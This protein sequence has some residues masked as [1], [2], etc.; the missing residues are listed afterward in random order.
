MGPSDRLKGHAGRAERF[1]L[2]D[3]VPKLPRIHG[4]IPQYHR[5]RRRSHQWLSED[6]FESKLFRAQS[7][8]EAKVLE[9]KSLEL[10]AA[11]LADR[12]SVH[13]T[14]LSKWRQPCELRRY[15]DQFRRTLLGLATFGFAVAGHG[16]QT[17]E[18]TWL[19]AA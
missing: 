8:L 14:R 15:M 3:E 1:E 6:G 12:E 2:C 17:L 19:L 16:F 10:G 9:R 5:S 4:L 18:G 13:L 7:G 11:L